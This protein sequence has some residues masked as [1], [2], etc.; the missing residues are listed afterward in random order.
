MRRKLM[1]NFVRKIREAYQDYRDAVKLGKAVTEIENWM[2]EN[3]DATKEQKQAIADAIY[4][5][6]GGLYV[7]SYPGGP[8]R[9]MSPENRTLAIAEAA[10][11]KAMHAPGATE[12]EKRAAADRL[13]SLK[14]P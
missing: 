6:Y 3:P 13:A 12:E 2:K 4:D 5:K 14:A 1:F 10:A 7:R 8:R 9:L 11:Y